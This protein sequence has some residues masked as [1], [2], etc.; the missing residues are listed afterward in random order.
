MATL[1]RAR[2]RIIAGGPGS[3]WRPA[4]A[5]DYQ[6][7]GVSVELELRS[8]EDGFYVVS[9]SDSPLLPGGDTWHATKEEALHQAEFECGVKRDDWTNAT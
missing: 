7:Q 6:C 5:A 8:E 1:M 9:T 4:G 2:A 3:G